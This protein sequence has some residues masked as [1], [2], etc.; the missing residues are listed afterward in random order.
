MFDTAK[1]N[2]K[3]I[4][5][6][7]SEVPVARIKIDKV[8]SFTQSFPMKARAP[9]ASAVIA[10]QT[11]MQTAII[12]P[13]L[14]SCRVF[15]NLGSKDEVSAAITVIIPA[16]INAQVAKTDLDRNALIPQTP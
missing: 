4:P 16:D 9:A 6:R 15:L 3:L 2:P 11:I 8:L 14:S 10:R 7:H 5:K 12:I 13:D 1:A